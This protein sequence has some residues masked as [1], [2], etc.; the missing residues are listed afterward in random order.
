[1]NFADLQD[2]I[3]DNTSRGVP[4]ITRKNRVKVIDKDLVGLEVD[5]SGCLRNDVKRR[6]MFKC[7]L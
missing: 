4:T 3:R 2:A 7:S 5:E 1:M 6:L